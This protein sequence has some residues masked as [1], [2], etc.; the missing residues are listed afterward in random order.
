[1]RDIGARADTDRK[2]VLHRFQLVFQNIK[3][4]IA[5]VQKR[6]RLNDIQMRGHSTK[7]NLL[8][9]A[10]QLGLLGLYF[11]ALAAKRIEVLAAGEKLL[12][13]L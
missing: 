13:D 2:A 7:E 4:F 6:A 9:R 5:Q 1:M 12:R 11:G 10:F 3:V 8:F